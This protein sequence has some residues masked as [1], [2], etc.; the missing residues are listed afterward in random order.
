MI[1]MKYYKMMRIIHKSF[2]ILPSEDAPVLIS[3]IPLY[4]LPLFGL[5]DHDLNDWIFRVVDFLEHF[6]GAKVIHMPFMQLQHVGDAVNPSIR[7]QQE[8]ILGEEAGV[9]DPPP[10]ILGLEMGIREA[11]ENFLQALFGEILAK[12]SHSVGSYHS[13]VVELSWVL[14]AISSDLL[15]HKVHHLVSDL[16]SQDQFF[17]KEK[18]QTEQES[19]I[20]ASDVNDRYVVAI[21]RIVPRLFIEGRV[22]NSIAVSSVIFFLASLEESGEMRPPIHKGVMRRIGERG[23]V[24]RINMRP[25]PVILLLGDQ[26]LSLDHLPI[27]LIIVGLL[28]GPAFPLHKRNIIIRINFSI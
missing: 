10:V 18:R 19:S 2:E 7:L 24:E 1:P 11:N 13:D 21:H 28:A 4:F 16:H 9:N 22:L 20:A 14:N 17:G 5:I 27:A 23:A 26:P 3:L 25:H 8:G 15:G 6:M 12:V